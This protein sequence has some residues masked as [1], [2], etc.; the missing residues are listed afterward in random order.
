MTNKVTVIMLH[1]YRFLHICSSLV[2]IACQFAYNIFKS[3]API[4][5]CQYQSKIMDYRSTFYKLLCLLYYKVAK[6]KDNAFLNN[7]GNNPVIGAFIAFILSKTLICM[8]QLPGAIYLLSSDVHLFISLMK[9]II[10]CIAISASCFNFLII[11]KYELCFVIAFFG[12]YW[13]ISISATNTRIPVKACAPNLGEFRGATPLFC[14]Q[15]LRA[16][17]T[18]LCRYVPYSPRGCALIGDNCPFIVI[19]S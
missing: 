9:I 11:I 10:F 18:P 5:T 19:Y 6:I 8:N 7:S 15:T 12:I 4:A 13:F 3:I 2:A 17:A 1:V 16:T 14:T